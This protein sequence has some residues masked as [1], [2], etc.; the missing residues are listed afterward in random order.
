MVDT[1]VESKYIDRV[2]PQIR[3][4]SGNLM[5]SIDFVAW[6]IPAVSIFIAFRNNGDTGGGKEKV[7]AIPAAGNGFVMCERQ[8]LGD[9]HVS[10]D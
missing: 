5:L 10:G 4:T 1:G 6:I 7:W 3:Q 9:E 2:I 8:P